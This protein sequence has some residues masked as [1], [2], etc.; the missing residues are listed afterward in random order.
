M[1]LAQTW[2][3]E[4]EEIKVNEGKRMGKRMTCSDIYGVEGSFRKLVI[5]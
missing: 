3:S 2:L 1:L 4:V 5:D